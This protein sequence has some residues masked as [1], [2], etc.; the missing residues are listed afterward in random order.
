[1]RECRYQG[2]CEHENYNPCYPPNGEVCRSY[3]PMP[4][5][6]ELLKLASEIDKT[7]EFQ[8]KM[9]ECRFDPYTHEWLIKIRSYS[10]RIREAVGA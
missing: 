1:M 2:A 8:S 4:D 10:S 6:A 3:Q 5:V 7:V 9:Q